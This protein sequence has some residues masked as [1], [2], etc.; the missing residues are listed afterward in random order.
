MAL[1]LRT[2]HWTNGWV[3]DMTNIMAHGP[4]SSHTRKSPQ[5]LPGGGISPSIEEGLDALDGIASLVHTFKAHLKEALLR[6]RD[7]ER[8]MQDALREATM[9]TREEAAER[10]RMSLSQLDQLVKRGT[11]AVTYYDRRPRFR[12]IEIIR[13]EEAHTRPARQARR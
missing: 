11:I 3:L 4:Q 7:Y 1:Y 9:L 10:L 8:G 12:L 5:R 6:V 13:F 2:N